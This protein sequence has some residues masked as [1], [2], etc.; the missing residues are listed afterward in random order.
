MP[1]AH[2]SRQS[3]AAALRP[4][5]G[6]PRLEPALP[7]AHRATVG[8]DVRIEPAVIRSSSERTDPRAIDH[9]GRSIDDEDV[10]RGG[11][12]GDE[13]GRGAAK[14]D[15][16]VVG[17]DRGRV[18]VLVGASV[19][20]RW[21]ALGQRGACRAERARSGRVGATRC[22]ASGRR[23]ARRRTC[24]WPRPSHV[25]QTAPASRRMIRQRR[26]T[27]SRSVGIAPIEM[28]TIQRPSRT[29]GVR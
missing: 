15:E 9:T 16:T 22:R 7:V 25:A 18:R 6:V 13:V 17:C 8:G 27:C 12:T 19:R 11:V 2:A 26:S 14:G 20:L 29:A 5:D 21:D 3:A 28:R 1:P 10:P 4:R 24:P 23:G